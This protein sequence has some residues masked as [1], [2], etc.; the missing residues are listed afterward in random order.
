M[1]G[2]QLQEALNCS[3]H[4]GL[5]SLCHLGCW[6]A[7]ALAKALGWDTAAKAGARPPR[8]WTWLWFRPAVEQLQ[9]SGCRHL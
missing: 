1:P 5:H 2:G 4:A 8:T 9:G 6:L 7:L 3:D